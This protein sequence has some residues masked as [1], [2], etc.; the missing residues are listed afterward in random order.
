VSREERCR[1]ALRRDGLILLESR[2]RAA[3]ASGRG[4]YMIV[5]GNNC[6]FAGARYELT[7]EDVEAWIAAA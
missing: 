2:A 4:R 3:H 7:L 1:R 6:V 5:D